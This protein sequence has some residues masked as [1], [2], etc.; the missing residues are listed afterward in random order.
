ME[1]KAS[2]RKFCLC[3]CACWRRAKY[4]PLEALRP[5]ALDLLEQYADK[6]VKQ[7]EAMAAVKA[8]T[9]GGGL[10]GDF[11]ML[12]WAPKAPSGASI[13]CQSSV[14]WA[15]RG[16]ATGRGKVKVGRERNYQA[17]LLR[18]ILGN[19][20][21]PVALEPSLRTPAVAALAQAAYEERALPVGT[22]RPDRLAVL[23]DP[24]EEAGC[25]DA[26]V[27]DHLRGPGTHVRGCWPV[28]LLTD[29]V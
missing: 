13:V 22:L 29:R 16:Y 12:L 7:R 1:G 6:Q 15:V 2:A 11:S 14:W 20:F 24:L 17:N 27:L 28:D 18:D 21:R 9:T 3:A 25:A 4:Y 23:A 8:A 5:R 10:P 19:P 26:A